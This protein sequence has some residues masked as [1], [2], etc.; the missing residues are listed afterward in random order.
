MS[1]AQSAPAAKLI[2]LGRHS[3]FTRCSVSMAAGSPEFHKWDTS[4][5]YPRSNRGNLESEEMSGLRD[6]K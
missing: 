6:R 1:S 4:V 2:C 5:Q 3:Q